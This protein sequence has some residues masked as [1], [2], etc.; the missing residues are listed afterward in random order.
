MPF[1]SQFPSVAFS[2][3]MRRFSPYLPWLSQKSGLSKKNAFW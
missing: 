2:L 3:E 1:F